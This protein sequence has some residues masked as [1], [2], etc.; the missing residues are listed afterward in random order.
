MLHE[1]ANVM[2]DPDDIMYDI[3]LLQEEMAELGETDLELEDVYR[4]LALAIADGK[5]IRASATWDTEDE[6]DEYE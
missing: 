3:Y 6:G 5:P 4:Q 1:E 2:Y